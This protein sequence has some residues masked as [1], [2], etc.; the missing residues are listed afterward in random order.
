[1]SWACDCVCVCVRVCVCVCVCVLYV[2]VCTCVASGV[3][4][5]VLYCLQLDSSSDEFGT[6]S[7]LGTLKCV[8]DTKWYIVKGEY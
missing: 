4:C 3:C 7:D 2:C 5:V 8:D 1:M 6:P